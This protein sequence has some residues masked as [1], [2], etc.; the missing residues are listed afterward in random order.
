MLD[1]K[2]IEKLVKVFATRDEV[3]AQTDIK[4]LRTDLNDLLN[5]VDA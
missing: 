5:A 4:A 2:D 3:A 1:D